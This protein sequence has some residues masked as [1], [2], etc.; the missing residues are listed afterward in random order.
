MLVLHA[1]T[2]SAIETAIRDTAR[3]PCACGAA[4]QRSG[5]G[6]G[7]RTYMQQMQQR[8]AKHSVLCYAC[9]RPTAALSPLLSTPP[10]SPFALSS[11]YTHTWPSFAEGDLLF[12]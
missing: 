9:M 8:H 1:H 3:S 4:T 10:P 11:T 12:I 6:H 5:G 7:T 2:K